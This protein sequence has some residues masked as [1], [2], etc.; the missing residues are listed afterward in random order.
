MLSF[1]VRFRSFSSVAHNLFFDIAPSAR[2]S[3]TNLIVIA[4]RLVGEIRIIDIC[5]A[6]NVDFHPGVRSI[7]AAQ[8]RH[9]TGNLSRVIAELPCH[10]TENCHHHIA[11]PLQIG[12]AIVSI[13][14]CARVRCL[15]NGGGVAIILQPCRSIERGFEIA[16]DFV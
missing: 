16:S 13:P 4:A 1:H 15:R 8:Q 11:V 10:F 5:R 2:L 12:K 9:L 14:Q 3:I 7:S 6:V